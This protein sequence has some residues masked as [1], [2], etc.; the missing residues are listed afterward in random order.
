M[1]DQSLSQSFPSQPLSS[2]VFEGDNIVRSFLDSKGD[3]WF[4]GADVCRALGISDAKQAIER[5]DEDERG[6]YGIPSGG[7]IQQTAVI[8][9]SG[10]YSLILSSRKPEAKRFK[11]WITSEV[12][13]AIRKTGAYAMPNLSP[14]EIILAQAQRLVDHE[15]QLANH[16]QRIGSLEAR[17]NAHDEWANHYTIIGYC[18]LRKL[19]SPTPNQAANWGKRAAALS[20]ERNIII[21]KTR[22][23]R[24]GEVNTYHIS[25]LDAVIGN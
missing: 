5:L 12:L 6:R 2:F 22:D 13:P 23:S 7:G 20:R 18:N 16:D 4:V 10:L 1:S 19:P 9:E 25:I 11:K 3:P 17:V 24:Y 15:R 21:G 14:A 8:N